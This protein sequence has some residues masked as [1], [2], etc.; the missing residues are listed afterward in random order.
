MA[1]KK[2]YGG[3]FNEQVETDVTKRIYE[4]YTVA[5]RNQEDTSVEFESI[6]DILECKRTEKDYEWLSDVFI[7]EYA[8]IHLTEASQ[9]A[10]Q[11]FPTR[12]FVD[13][14]LDGTNPESKK[15]ADVAKKFINSMLNVKNIHHYHKYMRVRGINSTY[16]CAYAVGSWKQQIQE[17]NTPVQRPQNA[18][19]AYDGTPITTTVT[20]NK[21]SEVIIEDRFHYEVP[22]PRNVFTDN[23]Y[24]YSIQ[25][26]EWVIVRSEMSYEQLKESEKTNGY[27]N[28]DVLKTAP[29]DDK[30]ETAKKTRDDG[31]ESYKT[32]LKY[33]DVLERFGKIWAIVDRRDDS[34]YPIEIS[35]AYDGQGNLS[36]NAE[37]VESIVTIACSGS[38]QVL[39]RFQPTPFRTSKN[40][41]FRPIIRGINYIHPTKDVG[42]S[43]GKYSKELQVALNDTINLSNDRVK[44][45]T[46][47]T[48]KVRKYALE[49][50]D[51]I[52]F[53]P[54]H[55]MVVENPDDITEFVIRD[56]MQ[57]ALGQAQMFINKMQQVES[58]YPTTMGDLPGRAS[59]TATAIQ[60]A[61]SRTN[62]RANYKSL[63]FEYT[64]LVEFYWMMMQM[65]YQFMR[66]ETAR[67]IMGD[68]AQFFDPDADYHFQP[69]SSNIEVEYNK[70]QKVKNLDQMVGR[71]SGLVQFMPGIIFPILKIL[72]TQME[73]LGQENQEILPYLNKVIEMG[74]NPQ[75]K[76]GEQPADAEQPMTSNQQGIPVQGIEEQ[77]R[78]GQDSMPPV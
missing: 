44:L 7:P 13:I 62:L 8:S 72:Q 45:A 55:M 61:E 56:N 35:P 21:T 59:T 50:N 78:S 6:I 37:L 41:P 5:E 66:P 27:F 49:D 30:T 25:E 2:K 52:Y 17:V 60:G 39:I 48:L 20:E 4:E 54:E 51:S 3:K 23:S 22:D 26:K 34:G 38:T 63:T 12:D 43:D 31:G 9:W 64:F 53:E 15:K 70:N 58:I 1:R 77:V 24:C 28:L 46:M 75:G 65:G 36:D 67:L 10:N 57:G 74:M 29:T 33:F 14:Y 18:G 73:L 19:L 69:V 16:G 42:M 71:I 76:Q 32:Q 40:V 47:P 68:D 11:Y